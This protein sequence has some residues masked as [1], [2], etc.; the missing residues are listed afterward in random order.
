MIKVT[1]TKTHKIGDQYSMDFPKNV[2]VT[3]GKLVL[4][5]EPTPNRQNQILWRNKNDQLLLTRSSSND[6]IAI[7]PIIISETEKIEVG[8]WWYGGETRQSLFQ[9]KDEKDLAY[10][11]HVSEKFIIKYNKVLVLPEQF[12]Q[13]QL[14]LI[15]EGVYKDG[16]KLLIEV[17]RKHS[18]GGSADCGDIDLY[19]GS[20]DYNQ[21]KLNQQGH[22]IL[23]K[24]EE[25]M[26]TE[27]Q[28]LDVLYEMIKQSNKLLDFDNK[29]SKVKEWF[30]KNVK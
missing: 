22:C 24:V 21:I 14:E 28:V 10:K 19:D 16:D 7:K 1:N 5:E 8:D 12:S 11:T 26:Y 17:E 2:T 3:E 25:K 27:T 9:V 6:L 20:Y 15:V 18:L 23:Y 29:R 13:Q 30:E 4:I